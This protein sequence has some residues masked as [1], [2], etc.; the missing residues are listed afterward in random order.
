MTVIDLQVNP[1]QIVYPSVRPVIKIDPKKDT[2]EIKE[3]TQLIETSKKTTVEVVKE[4]VSVSKVVTESEETIRTEVIGG[5]NKKYYV[6]IV[7]KSDEE[8]EVVNVEGGEETE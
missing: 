8:P 1:A 7:K 5:D 6:T 3:Y 2:E 4:V